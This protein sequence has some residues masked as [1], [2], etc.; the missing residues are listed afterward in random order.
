MLAYRKLSLMLTALTL[1][2]LLL[3]AVIFY[4][5]IRYQQF[6]LIPVILFLPLLVLSLRYTTGQLQALFSSRHADMLAAGGL[7]ATQPGPEDN[8]KQVLDDIAEE[9]A[10]ATG[11]TRPHVAVC[12]SAGLNALI[13]PAPGPGRQG[14]LLVFTTGITAALNRHELQAVAAHLFAHE[15]NFESMFVSTASAMYAAVFAGGDIFLLLNLA[16]LYFGADGSF[17]TGPL[18]V[19]LTMMMLLAPVVAATMAQLYLIRRTRFVD[20][21]RAV[22]I[23]KDPD[24]MVSALKKLAQGGE[25]LRAAYSWTNVHFYFDAVDDPA[26]KYPWQ[27]LATHPAPAVSPG[28]N[29]LR[30]GTYVLKHKS[31]PCLHHC[32]HALHE[33]AIQGSP[34]QKW[35][36]WRDIG[37]CLHLN[38][39]IKSRPAV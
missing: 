25:R 14:M 23:T 5:I 27:K 26:R 20:D 30:V 37:H 3:F 2:H 28:I 10:I 11:S 29:N 32:G 4:V 13:S 21:A 8:L 34:P 31:P 22:E 35:T 1:G 33:R 7:T 16:N 24:S 38:R 9:M 19:L 15:R 36:G 39:H 12:R 6:G 17:S 18:V